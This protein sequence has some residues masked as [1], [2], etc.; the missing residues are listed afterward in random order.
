MRNINNL[1]KETEFI[2]NV[3]PSKKKKIWY[4]IS[5]YSTDYVK[6]VAFLNRLEN[7]KNLKIIKCQKE[8]K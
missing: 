4:K 7:L 8:P 5:Y 1:N 3:L 6:A 2:T